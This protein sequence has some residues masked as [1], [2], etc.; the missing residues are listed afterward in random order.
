MKTQTR[1]SRALAAVSNLV[2]LN[3]ET[4]GRSDWWVREQE[5][6]KSRLCA[7]KVALAAL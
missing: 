5:A 4:T 2:V 1:I 7:A 6:L 3:A